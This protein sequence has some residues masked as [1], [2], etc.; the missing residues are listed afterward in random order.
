MQ[1]SLNEL[2]KTLQS[3]NE[4]LQLYHRT[5][6]TDPQVKKAFRDASIQRFEYCLEFCWK[7]A[8]KVLGSTT[9]AAKPAVREMARNNLISNPDLWMEFVEARNQTSHSYDEEVA[10]TVFKSIEAFYPEATR[11][12][13]ALKSQK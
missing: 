11:L 10:K 1:T 3:L 7:T 13:E 4:S 5:A 9:L 12:L 8:M 6:E 2:A